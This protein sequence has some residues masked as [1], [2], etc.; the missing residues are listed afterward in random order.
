[1]A[2]P[3]DSSLWKQ[4]VNMW[5]KLEEMTFWEVRKGN[6]IR[7]WE[8]ALVESGLKPKEKLLQQNNSVYLATK[9]ENLV[10]DTGDWNWKLLRDKLDHDTLAKIQVIPPPIRTE[11]ADDKSIWGWY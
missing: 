5:P 11:M 8:D 1:M 7:V 6:T 10:N 9:V 3:N 2:K 4:L